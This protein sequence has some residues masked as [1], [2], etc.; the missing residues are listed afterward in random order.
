MWKNVVE[1]RMTQMTI[2]RMRIAWRL[3]KATDRHSEYVTL[4]AFHCN[5]GYTNTPLCYVIR[6]LPVM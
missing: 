2:R 3:P 4:I 5:N 1:L 6:I